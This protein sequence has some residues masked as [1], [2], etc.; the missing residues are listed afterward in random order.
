MGF[1]I[2][3]IGGCFFSDVW[4]V[5]VTEPVLQYSADG[6][7][8][9]VEW[10]RPADDESQELHHLALQAKKTQAPK[11]VC[12]DKAKSNL[13]SFHIVDIY[14]TMFCELVITWLRTD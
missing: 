13:Q 2:F 6:I 14:N 10:E 12:S 4:V 8:Q 3:Y 9:V 7:K 5:P 1:R 11:H